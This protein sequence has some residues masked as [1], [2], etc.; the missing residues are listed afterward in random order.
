MELALQA[1]IALVIGSWSLV[2]G[3]SMVSWDA[4]G[5]VQQPSCDYGL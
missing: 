5:C 2:V 1:E 4:E 3:M